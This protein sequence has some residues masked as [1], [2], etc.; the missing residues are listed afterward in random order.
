MP[1][2]PVYHSGHRDV[3][4]PRIFRTDSKVDHRNRCIGNFDDGPLPTGALQ[5]PTVPW[6]KYFLKKTTIDNDFLGPLIVFSGF[7]GE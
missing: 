3:G 2:K 7:I 5:I 1:G 6:L 4:R